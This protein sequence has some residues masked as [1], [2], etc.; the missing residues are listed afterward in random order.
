MVKLVEDEPIIE[1]SSK[2]KGTKVVFKPDTKI[3]KNFKYRSEYVIKM[4]KYYVYLNPGLTIIFNGEK[5]K[6]DDGL[7]DL[8]EDNNNRIR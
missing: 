7:K 3:F 8:L 1:N 2:R 4:L 6:S 5:L